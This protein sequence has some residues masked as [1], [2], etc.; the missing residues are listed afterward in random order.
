VGK[1]ASSKAIIASSIVSDD[2]ILPAMTN[3]GE[4]IPELLNWIEES[5]ARLVLNTWSG[6][7]VRSSIT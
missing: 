7:F 5:D 6:Q 2:E 3:D 4:E 1:Q